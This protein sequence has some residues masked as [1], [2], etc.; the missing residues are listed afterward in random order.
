MYNYWL[1]QICG[2][3]TAVIKWLVFDIFCSG[4]RRLLVATSSG[5]DKLLHR[6]CQFGR[7]VSTSNQLWRV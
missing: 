7:R 5:V 2:I 3:A 6:V 4:L 1:C